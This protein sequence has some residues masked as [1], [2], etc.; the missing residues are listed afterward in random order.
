[1]AKQ[2]LLPGA[3]DYTQYVGKGDTN[4]YDS[5]AKRLRNVLKATQG[6]LNSR[7]SFNF[8]QSKLPDTELK[9]A[10]MR[11]A[12]AWDLPMN[13]LFGLPTT[14]SGYVDPITGGQLTLES[15]FRLMGIDKS[16][17]LAGQLKQLT[18]LP[19]N[20]EDISRKFGE[21]LPSFAPAYRTS[22][23]VMAS[24]LTAMADYK[25][26]VSYGQALSMSIWLSQNSVIPET[27]R[28]N[29][30]VLKD[31]NLTSSQKLTVAAEGA[32][33]R[34]VPFKDAQDMIAMFH[35]RAAEIIAKHKVEG[36]DVDQAI[37]GARLELARQQG[38]KVVAGKY[39]DVQGQTIL[40]IDEKTKNL[41]N[42]AADI[43]KTLDIRD[44]QYENSWFNKHISGPVSAA[45]RKGVSG[46]EGSF[47]GVASDV[48][49]FIG[50]LIPDSF[51][52]G[53]VASGAWNMTIQQAA[54]RLNE[55]KQEIWDQKTDFGN[56]FIGAM[57]EDYGW[58]PKSGGVKAA[59]AAL[60]FIFQM[61]VADPVMWGLRGIKAYNEGRVLTGTLKKAMDPTDRA[62]AVY[63]SLK[64]G[65]IAT[66]KLVLGGL[67]VPDYL[68]KAAIED[69]GD[70]T[71]FINKASRL[72]GL[73]IKDMPSSLMRNVFQ[74]V[75]LLN[76]IGAAPEE[77]SDAVRGVFYESAGVKSV[78][79][80][81]AN[82][83]K[84]L[85]AAKGP[86]A[87]Y[88]QVAR[89]TGMDPA[90]VK[91]QYET[92]KFV[93][94]KALRLQQVGKQAKLDTQTLAKK[95]VD[96]APYDKK[97]LKIMDGIAEENT[98]KYLETLDQLNHSFQPGV[99][100]IGMLPEVPHPSLRAWF[101][102]FTS[103]ESATRRAWR[104]T[105]SKMPEGFVDSTNKPEVA[106]RR[107]ATVSKAFTSEQ[108][109]RGEA[110]IIT[111]PEN[112]ISVFRGFERE[113]IANIGKD[114]GFSP[115][116][117]KQFATRIQ[118][119][120]D[121]YHQITL[122]A[123]EAAGAGTPFPII[124]PIDVRKAMTDAQFSYKRLF[125]YTKK[126]LG[127]HLSEDAI[128]DVTDSRIARAAVD[129]MLQ[130]QAK[131]WK[132]LVTVFRPAYI[133]RIPAGEEQLKFFATVGALNRLTTSRL[134]TA[135]AGKIGAIR[136]GLLGA[137]ITI[138]TEDADNF[139]EWANRTGWADIKNKADILRPGEEVLDGRII[140]RALYN[141]L[142]PEDYNKTYP[143]SGLSDE[144]Y[145]HGTGVDF[146]QF[147]MAQADQEALVGPGM[148]VTNRGATASDYAL[149]GHSTV[150][151]SI[152]VEASSES[153]ARD[154]AYNKFLD[155]YPN[156]EVVVNKVF[157]AKS[158]S[159]HVD[160][161]VSEYK[162]H[163]VMFG[164]IK[165]NNVLNVDG[166]L[167]QATAS[168]LAKAVDKLP[169]N[170]QVD[171]L[172][173]RLITLA[174]GV[175]SYT[176]R[177]GQ[178]YS[179][180]EEILGNKAAVNKLLDKA[181]FDAIL[182]EG[183]VRT[184]S[185][186]HTAFNL[187]NPKKSW[188]PGKPEKGPTV[189]EIVEG[190]AR[191]S[192][193]TFT[194]RY[195]LHVHDLKEFELGRWRG[196]VETLEQ[197]YSDTY[198]WMKGM[199]GSPDHNVLLPRSGDPLSISNHLEAWSKSLSEHGANGTIGHAVL[200]DIANGKSQGEI[201]SH[202]KQVLA[203]RPGQD[204][205]REMGISIS[206]I[207]M[208]A[209]TAVDKWMRLTYANAD[210]QVG[211]QVAELALGNDRGMLEEA[212]QNIPVEARPYVQES[213]AIF[214]AGK[215][216]AWAKIVDVFGK[217]NFEIPHRRLSH[218]PFGKIWF[219]RA[220][221]Q[222]HEVAAE[223]GVKVTPELEASFREQSGKF[224]GEML[225]NTM[226]DFSTHSRLSEMMG[227]VFPFFNPYEQAW[228]KWAG[229]IRQNPAVAGW[230][231]HVDRAAKDSGLIFDDPQT[232]QSVFN[233]SWFM[234]ASPLMYLA[235]GVKG[236]RFLSPV[237]GLNLF[238]SDV[239]HVPT[240][241][242]GDFP[243]PAPAANP[244]AVMAIQKLLGQEGQGVV[245]E[246]LP[247]AWRKSLVDWAFHYG[248]ASAGSMFPG[249]LQ[250]AIIAA[251]P[252]AGV[253]RVFGS[254][255]RMNRSA[256]DFYKEQVRRFGEKNAN[257]DLAKSQARHFAWLKVLFSLTFISAPN[258]ELPSDEIQTEYDN[259][260]AKYGLDQATE[261][262]TKKYPDIETLIRGKTFQ[263]RGIDP[264]RPVDPITG[265]NAAHMNLPYSE[266]ARQVMAQPYWKEFAHD[267]PEWAWLLIPKEARTGEFS[268]EAY[269]EAISN[270]VLK[271][272]NV[273]AWVEKGNINKGWD[274]ALPIYEQF[275]AELQAHGF[276]QGDAGYDALKLE[277]D[278]KLRD[279]AKVWPDW[280]TLY[281][282]DAPFGG[283]P[284][285]VNPVIL[286]QAKDL[287]KTPLFA[288][289]EAGQSMIL[290]LRER[291]II[292]DDMAKVNASSITQKVSQKTGLTKH[293]EET[294]A[295][296]TQTPGWK[297]GDQVND[298]TDFGV[299]YRT[300]F[301]NDLLQ[302][303][304]GQLTAGQ[305][306][307]DHINDL[308]KGVEYGKF[309]QQ[310]SSKIDEALKAGSPS[311]RN[312]KFE[313][314]RNL[315]DAGYNFN[316]Y[317]PTEV[318]WKQKDKLEKTDYIMGLVGRP[319]IFYSRFDRSLLG[320]SSTP[321]IE[322]AW[323]AYS[324]KAASVT[325]ALNET[326][327]EWRLIPGKSK[328]MHEEVAALA[329]KLG[330]EI[331][332][333][334]E[335]IKIANEWGGAL[336]HSDFFKTDIKNG[337]SGETWDHFLDAIGQFQA[338]A[339]KEEWTGTGDFDLQAR[340]NWYIWKKHIRTYQTQLE[341]I[342]PNFKRDVAR[343][344]KANGFDDFLDYFIPS[345]YF[346]IG[347]GN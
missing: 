146:N 118:H 151:S 20:A 131:V 307:L 104:S 202:I 321:A 326:H 3:E 138:S 100:N 107:W 12:T 7:F 284:Q 40:N 335:Q 309:Q 342:D 106:F 289:T 45:W 102:D 303:D 281:G 302:L 209:E 310:L 179:R 206:D 243:L 257:M 269:Q 171:E 203:S 39:A 59:G 132:P 215:A 71:N 244:A 172:Y 29:L 155:I 293:Y 251:A 258:I 4:T 187:L 185:E 9:Y 74:R 221:R 80:D 17:I 110:A 330:R 305:K 319:Y 82:R 72:K 274:A 261:M 53:Q 135:T 231:Y 181:G 65:N 120:Q 33:L 193:V 79:A 263:A 66:R 54:D 266:A 267:Y 42:A 6:T 48:E 60:E 294:V 273:D 332:G 222:M 200:D 116:M 214:H 216:G 128:H 318:W 236:A 272:F 186:E 46:I 157:K 249:W 70:M 210:P 340:A 73:Y 336:T 103:G 327:P 162:Q 16:D 35:P 78:Y 312:Q 75:R 31:A 173:D 83:W 329:R 85:A 205:L 276:A 67:N 295:E 346:P 169:R 112:A 148:Y 199:P 297:I 121:I 282:P 142:G 52:K 300:W 323:S 197:Q 34:E 246:H 43:E 208:E 133:L 28:E 315:I 230:I 235:T 286:Q 89:E 311:A 15:A 32:R 280:G 174:N 153:A 240:G 108:I 22:P 194:P 291:Q 99:Q 183:G 204:A 21:P 217:Y 51:E 299:F 229:I 94:D 223:N 93:Q 114:Y 113:M 150:N 182:Y 324:Q 228:A 296:L 262:L 77:I 117:S 207:P 26:E 86:E 57:A 130:I 30:V 328:K 213:E 301:D 343:L 50:K 242:A 270:G 156:Q 101:K 238:L 63:K 61:T 149:K 341:A 218:Q 144:E 283:Q 1:M 47:Y 41:L 126:T 140:D 259:T 253:A 264:N 211:K 165:I 254:E 23:Q 334:A 241:F 96:A 19:R 250:N 163:N 317:N 226:L 191:A 287:V 176:E 111:N 147:D 290:Y 233:S 212:L 345:D 344:N 325:K 234:L 224:A 24:Y 347:G 55:T 252:T 225:R 232:G 237:A 87:M 331:P 195:P 137:P 158:G 308:G 184:G 18:R 5:G 167:D 152:I 188:V 143:R 92:S 316:G 320:F 88:E 129:D 304:A 265:N 90:V 322:S 196:L 68:V 160:A 56:A 339:D 10:G 278:D 25:H 109:A 189:G 136:K 98:N 170:P 190:R 239:F 8:V 306:I 13:E 14:L 139:I 175:G 271:V 285:G 255:D 76:E 292:L 49:G 119:G 122:V 145:F 95:M 115:E 333:F 219:Q 58:D 248:P 161:A 154:A 178:V 166:N 27:F 91:A 62:W 141:E 105:L 123:A 125:N 247:Y 81:Y 192:A 180:L 277:R 177:G 134:F 168:R 84:E 338:K 314:I 298:T 275:K 260:V 279:I 256:I 313:D 64:G 164:R 69:T 124:N 38:T 245:G 198:D 227:I 127:G 337:G 2:S 159:W 220:M 97:T 11:V 201:I 44:A 36:G 288:Q 268:L 37:A